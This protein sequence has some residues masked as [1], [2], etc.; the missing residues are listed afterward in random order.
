MTRVE[1][2]YCKMLNIAGLKFG[3]DLNINRMRLVKLIVIIH[4]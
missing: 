2:L 1:I 4:V 3:A